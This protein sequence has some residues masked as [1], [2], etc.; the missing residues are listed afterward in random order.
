MLGLL[1]AVGRRGV[2][3]L[4]LGF[5]YQLAGVLD[6]ARAGA[7]SAAIVLVLVGVS[8]ALDDDAFTPAAEFPGMI[9]PITPA[10]IPKQS[11]EEF[12]ASM[13]ELRTEVD[14]LLAMQDR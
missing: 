14:S 5:A 3:P 8:A 11:V 6:D 12:T 7:A 2:A 1:V 10:L 4:P 13:N 9:K